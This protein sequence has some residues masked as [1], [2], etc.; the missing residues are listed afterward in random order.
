MRPNAL[1]TKPLRIAVFQ[2]LIQILSRC[3]NALGMEPLFTFAALDHE[4]IRVIRHRALTKYLHV[5]RFKLARRRF[6]GKPAE[7][8]FFVD[9][10]QLLIIR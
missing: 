7:E 1:V 2:V 10:L 8:R 9:R 3:S 4:Q 5:V 6:V